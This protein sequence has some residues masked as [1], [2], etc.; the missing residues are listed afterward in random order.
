[1]ANNAS[2]LGLTASTNLTI[3]T[4][5]KVESTSEELPSPSE[6]TN[7]VLPV[8]VASKRR[9]GILAVS[10]KAADS[11]GVETEEEGDEQVVSVPEGLERLLADLVMSSSVHQKHAEQHDVAR[12]TTR[13]DVMNL[14]SSDWT[15]LGL[16]DV[17]EA[18][19][20][21]VSSPMS[22]KQE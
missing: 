13:L 8:D 5:H 16:L 15:N 3:Q 11:V 19:G 12:D 21:I 1:M 6:I 20:V 7:A 17:E 4:F 22:H 2:N 18:L 10:D 14:D 9:V